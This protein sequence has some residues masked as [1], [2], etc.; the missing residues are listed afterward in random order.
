VLFNHPALSLFPLMFDISK[1][2]VFPMKS[3]G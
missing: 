1:S 3:G 2:C